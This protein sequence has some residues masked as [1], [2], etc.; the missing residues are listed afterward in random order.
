MADDGPVPVVGESTTLEDIPL[1]SLKSTFDV[2]EFATDES[3]PRGAGAQASLPLSVRLTDSKPAVRRAAYS[4]LAA[5][6]ASTT[7][8]ELPVFEEH[9]AQLKAVLLDNASLCHEAG[10]EAT[11]LPSS[12]PTIIACSS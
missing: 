2:S 5:L 4:E 12:C 6:F 3:S 7:S 8:E 11:I 10:L 9:G 1:S